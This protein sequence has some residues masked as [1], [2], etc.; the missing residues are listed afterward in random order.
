MSHIM[1][2]ETLGLVSENNIGI[3]NY[4]S[5]DDIDISC[6]ARKKSPRMK[7]MENE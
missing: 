6:G 2:P 3:P 4:N 7:T 5:D 1:E